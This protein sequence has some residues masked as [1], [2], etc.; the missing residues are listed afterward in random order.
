MPVKVEE[1]YIVRQGSLDDESKQSLTPSLTSIEWWE[2]TG[3][4][5]AIGNRTKPTLFC[6]QR[7][8]K[9]S[10]NRTE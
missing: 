3:I 1:M 7:L 8:D 9:N 2:E 10:G 5:S 4:K 6:F